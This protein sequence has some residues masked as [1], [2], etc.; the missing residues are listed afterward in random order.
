MLQRHR[1]IVAIPP[2]FLLVVVCLWGG[3]GGTSGTGSALSV[4]EGMRGGEGIQ[5]TVIGESVLTSWSGVFFAKEADG[6]LSV[7]ALTSPVLVR[8][9]SAF[10]LV[11]VGWQ[12]RDDEGFARTPRHFLTQY[13]KESAV[14]SVTIP[15][16]F[17][18]V[19]A[20][21]VASVHPL[22]RD[23][24]WVIIDP[25][26]VG[27]E[28]HMVRL[29]SFPQSDTLP[30]AALP[31]TVERWGIRVREFLK[32]SEDPHVF[33]NQL[34]PEVR[35]IVGWFM[36]KGYPERAH[37]YREAIENIAGEFRVFLSEESRGV[38]EDLDFASVMWSSS[39]PSPA[40][41]IQ[42]TVGETLFES[43]PFDPETVK[44]NAYL[45]LRDMGALFTINTEI[46]P[47]S[48][49]SAE[50]HEIVFGDH[51]FDF[52]L[53]SAEQVLDGISMDGK[54]M[55]YPMGIEEFKRWVDSLGDVPLIPSP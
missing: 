29:K 7:A 15:D 28:D 14:Y 13:L 32:E 51:V 25:D 22:M 9:L 55:A 1:H 4:N 3:I 40:E 48:P 24:V 26:N 53:E 49:S 52:V 16:T 10:V 45:L 41:L 31:F 42:E 44:Q 27:N 37:R 50:I 33:L 47:V 17:A 6:H 46:V 21:L 30:E 36:E 38:L 2:V 8:T 5:K 11:P 23:R 18:T 35:D 43:I 34:I 20:W 54:L 12:W 19:D 39:E